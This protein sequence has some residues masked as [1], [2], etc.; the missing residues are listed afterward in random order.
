MKCMCDLHVLAGSEDVLHQ[1]HVIK[2]QCESEGFWVTV[3]LPEDVKSAFQQSRVLWLG[4][5]THTAGDTNTRSK[6][7]DTRRHVQMHCG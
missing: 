1:L 4:D 6:Q 2:H 5:V 7:D 3:K